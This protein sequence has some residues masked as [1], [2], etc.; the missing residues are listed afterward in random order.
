M[1]K[2]G[3]LVISH[4]SRESSWV[5]LVDEAVQ[6]LP[7]Q[8]SIPVAV[9]FLELVT[10]R[11]IQDG[12]DELEQQGVTDILVI[13]L[14]VSSGSTHVAEIAYALGAREEPGF[15]SDLEP[16]AVKSRIHYGS[17]MDDD[18]TI[19]HMVWDK[20]AELSHA[21]EQEAI[22]LVGHGSRHDGFRERWEKGAG[23]LAAK[24]QALSG[25]AAADTAFLNPDSVRS[26]V[27]Y[28][29]QEFGYQVIVSPL[30]LS[31]GYF[32]QT[33]IPKRL[34]GL[35]YRY[36]GKALLPHRLLTHW[37]HTQVLRMLQDLKL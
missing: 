33:V 8:E 4:G 9:S 35:N 24:V 30:F 21:P 12:I 31:D 17:P 27:A 19:A 11:L 15:D 13:P 6:Q 28:W 23:S 20:A 1:R 26:K 16:F 5:T 25:L 37:I 36:A 32:T 34:E 3:V 2:P 7:L 18:D 14:F 10:G 22:L 29:Q